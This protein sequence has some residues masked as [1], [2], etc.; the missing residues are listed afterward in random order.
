MIAN[1][2]NLIKEIDMKVIDVLQDMFQEKYTEDKDIEVVKRE[3][4][5]TINDEAT[6]E[7][8]VGKIAMWEREIQRRKEASADYIKDAES[9]KNRLEFLF[10]AELAKYAQKH[11]PKGK[12][13]IK[14]KSGT[15]G[16]RSLKE[17]VKIIDKDAFVTWCDKNEIDG[18]VVETR[19]LATPATEY[20]QEHGK[21]PEGCEL[22][23]ASEKFYT[24]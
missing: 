15:V 2:K 1:V 24:K 10:G 6:A 5:L 4:D 21:V 20:Y 14:F 11:L 16:F 23:E 17:K 7:A 12:K 18:Y 8:I 19:P 9:M 3:S 22:V 13:S